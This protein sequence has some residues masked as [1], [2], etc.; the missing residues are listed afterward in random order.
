MLYI[1]PNELFCSTY[2]ESN[3]PSIKPVK[4]SLD[5]LTPSWSSHHEPA[6]LCFSQTI[7]AY[8][9]L[10]DMGK[11]G[12]NTWCIAC[13]LNRK[14]NMGTGG[15]SVWGLIQPQV[16]LRDKE[17][18]MVVFSE[19]SF[20]VHYY[21]ALLWRNGQV[22]GVDGHRR[23]QKFGTGLGR[24]PSFFFFFF[25][26]VRAYVHDEE[27]NLEWKSRTCHSFCPSSDLVFIFLSCSFIF[28]SRIRKTNI[29][30]WTNL[31]V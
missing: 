24:N 18:S 28:L 4:I 5:C 17:Y 23:R 21:S 7:Q 22:E 14:T 30:G 27:E 13:P 3:R 26:L 15:F 29:Y 1:T 31:E 9:L 2:L 25:F 8:H 6:F 20:I 12:S 16:A 10:S 19:I 11:R